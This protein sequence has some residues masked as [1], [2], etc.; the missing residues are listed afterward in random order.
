MANHL[1]MKSLTIK[2]SHEYKL[3]LPGCVSRNYRKQYLETLNTKLRM[4]CNGT[5]VFSLCLPL[6]PN[7]RS[8]HIPWFFFQCLIFSTTTD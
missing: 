1:S 3:S 4:V 2:Q 8:L 7:S 5:D 6:D